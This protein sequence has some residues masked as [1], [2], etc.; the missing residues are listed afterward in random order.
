MFVI[1]AD[2]GFIH[3]NENLKR[4]LLNDKLTFLAIGGLTEHSFDSSQMKAIV[5]RNIEF[6]KVN[7]GLKL[8]FS[9]IITDPSFVDCCF[10]RLFK[11]DPSAIQVF[12][13]KANK[14]FFEVLL[15]AQ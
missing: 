9:K 7:D 1:V 11:D 2:F 12:S 13:T 10:L 6:S 15:E 3:I 4:L 8:E 14:S 5:L